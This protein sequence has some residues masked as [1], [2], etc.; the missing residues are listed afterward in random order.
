MLP[1]PSCTTPIWSLDGSVRTESTTTPRM[2]AHTSKHE[3]RGTNR[4]ATANT[5]QHRIAHAWRLV[6]LCKILQLNCFG[7][8]NNRCISSCLS[9]DGWI[10]IGA[11]NEGAWMAVDFLVHRP[12]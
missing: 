6:D 2:F 1:T 9:L 8:I 11:M 5:R 3:S 12:G 7:G 10:F 4:S